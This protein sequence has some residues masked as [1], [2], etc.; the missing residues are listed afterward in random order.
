M[1]CCGSASDVR[2]AKRQPKTP[3]AT[4]TENLVPQKY[5]DHNS[6]SNHKSQLIYQSRIKNHNLTIPNPMAAKP[7]DKDQD[8]ADSVNGDET[9]EKP[10]PPQ[11][12]NPRTTQTFYA[13]VDGVQWTNLFVDSDPG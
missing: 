4:P 2:E 5:N 9:N 8:D 3:A 11:S 6:K 7:K 10:V 1:S 13:E 12:P